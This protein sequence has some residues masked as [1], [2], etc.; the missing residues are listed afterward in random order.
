MHPQHSPHLRANL[1]AHQRKWSVVP[2][3]NGV[4]PFTDD[5]WRQLHG[6][7][8]VAD[9]GRWIDG[10]AGGRPVPGTVCV[11]GAGLGHVVDLLEGRP[12]T[13]VVLLEPEPATV[14]WFLA[15]RDW[16]GAIDAGRLLVL[17]GPAFEGAQVA[18][19]LFGDG[20]ADPLV[21]AHPVLGRARP[22]STRLAAQIIG[23]A[24]VGARG[25][26]DA[27]RKFAAPYLVNT[28]Q[29][30]PVM[31]RAQSVE[32]LAGRYRGWPI[33]V[34]AAGPSLNRNVEALRRW[35]DQVVLLAVDTALKPLLAAGMPPDFVVALD[36]GEANARHLSGITVPASTS[37]V[38]EPSIAPR[39]FAAFGDRVFLFRV[40]DHAPWAWLRNRGMDCSLLRAWGSVVT[41]TLDLALQMG[42]DPVVCIGA[43]FA[44]TGGQPYARGTTYEEDWIVTAGPDR[45]IEWVWEQTV[46]ARGVPAVDVHGAEVQSAKGLL[47]FRDWLV[48][49][50]KR[51]GQPR[52]VNATG[53]GILHGGTWEQKA[54]EEIGLRAPGSR[55]GSTVSRRSP[56]Y[57]PPSTARARG[58]DTG[59]A[60]DSHLLH[61]L[62]SLP[63][64]V[65]V[66]PSGHIQPYRQSWK[67]Q[68]IAATRALRATRASDLERWS[69]P[70]NL[71]PV[72]EYGPRCAA[73]LVPPG[74]RVL[75]LGAG[76]EALA[77]HLPAGCGYTPS[78]LVPRSART[79]VA[80]LNRGELPPGAFD[81]VAI[82][83]TL[84]FVHD[85]EALLKALRARAPLSIVSYCGCTSKD[86]D[87]RLERGYFTDYTRD[88]F[89]LLCQ[90]AGWQV[91]VA[92]RLVPGPGF[93][94]WMF[95]LRAFNADSA[96]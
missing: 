63:T 72:W 25:N 94:Q 29:N 26:E 95:A 79:H 61:A 83:A 5:H 37:L 8:P 56:V 7:D 96:V 82:L 47:V 39:S 70:A 24:R 1:D 13:R 20:A 68:R 36:P 16:R 4:V 58:A 44:Y 71:D 50:S 53:A 75:D 88:E 67:R 80:D 27:R 64:P 78:D 22:E 31:A 21:L 74:S 19:R 43:D 41:S 23:R 54:I 89:V 35:R 52:L 91:V 6:D 12:D 76:D 85:V 65:T 69:D 40:A 81:V 14:P 59:T 87:T 28:L 62:L 38:A 92:E 86:L 45:T 84:E 73:R 3:W 77:A 2:S 15:R 30:V 60:A 9:A 48:E 90:K 66:E 34:A 55:P 17:A 93:E 49:E 51:P 10:A 33:V 11:I 18:W 57:R 32:A 42:G 46:A